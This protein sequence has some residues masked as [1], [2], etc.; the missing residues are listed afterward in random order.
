MTR[1]CKETHQDLVFCTER[2]TKEAQE[3][4]ITDCHAG[5]P[6]A[7]QNDLR[8]KI[9]EQMIEKN[10]GHGFMEHLTDSGA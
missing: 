7:H 6:C 2:R 10:E 8:A 9:R 5:N 4:H 1:G 3:G